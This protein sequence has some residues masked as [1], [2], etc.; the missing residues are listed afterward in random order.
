[1]QER[2][3]SEREGISKK[4]AGR[5]LMAIGALL[6]AA[7]FFGIGWFAHWLSLGERTRSLLWAIDT[8]RDR[9]YRDVDESKLFDKLFGA[10]SLDPY[11]RYY[12]Q[13]EYKAASAKDAGRG[14]GIG[15]TAIDD[16]DMVRLFRVTG[17]SPAE[18]AG[19]CAGMYV[20]RFG[21]SKE[22]LA[23]GTSEQFL[24]FV[25]AQ[26]GAFCVEC[27]FDREGAD[28]QVYT[29]ASAAYRVSY[30]SYR[31]SDGAFRFDPERLE[32]TAFGKP[33]AELDERTAYIRISEFH[34]TAAEEFEGCLKQMRERGRRDLIIDLRGNGGGYLSVLC[35]IAS[36]LMKEAKGTHPVVATARYRSGRET[37]F[38]APCNDYSAY[39]SEDSRIYL[40]ADENTASAS[41]CLI[42]ALVSYGTVGAEDIYVRGAGTK[43][44][45]YGKG[46]MQSYFTELSGNVLKLTVA[47]IF[48]PNGTSIHGVGVVAADADHGIDAPLIPGAT[49]EFLAEFLRRIA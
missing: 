34:G 33:F 30:V 14:E 15:V 22:A 13:E 19:L 40:L 47:E 12:T 24:A 25:R 8:A 46:I 23:A 32:P 2:E 16:A 45:S 18:R 28:A 26:E 27:G 31:D 4:R 39:F 1:M 44:H 43:A 11:S 10:F 5:A 35:E 17:N 3:H 38:T 6:L 41:E 37:A 20:F 48:W 42:G 36:H 21:A 49:D 9:Y 7:C 29:L